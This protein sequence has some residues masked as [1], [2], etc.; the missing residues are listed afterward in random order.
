MIDPDPV[1][2]MLWRWAACL[3]AFLLLCGVL[4][5]LGVLPE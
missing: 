1:Y 4:A 3:T 2:G 5:A